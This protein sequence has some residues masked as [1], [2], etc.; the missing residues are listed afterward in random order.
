MPTPARAAPPT[1]A[2]VLTCKKNKMNVRLKVKILIIFNNIKCD[3]IFIHNS[4]HSIQIQSSLWLC[5]LWS[6]VWY[7]LWYKNKSTPTCRD[8]GLPYRSHVTKCSQLLLVREYGSSW[9][10]I[11]RACF[12]MIYG[13]RGSYS[14]SRKLLTSNESQQTTSQMFWHLTRALL[15]SRSTPRLP[16]ESRSA[17]VSIQDFTNRRKVRI[18]WLR[19]EEKHRK[20]KLFWLLAFWL[21]KIR[22]ITTQKIKNGFKIDELNPTLHSLAGS[23]WTT[24]FL[25]M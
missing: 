24:L 9:P 16:K 11:S 8:S 17:P 6:S 18:Q 20:K 14:S 3:Y 25:P 5:W 1:A 10:T 2:A 13:S 12:T 21:N 15:L 23:K 4:T 22:A 19:E 7:I